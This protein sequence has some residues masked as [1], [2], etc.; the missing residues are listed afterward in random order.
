[1]FL[2]ICN[3][4]FCFARNIKIDKKIGVSPH[5]KRFGREFKGPRIPFG[6]EVMYKPSP[7]YEKKLKADG[8]EKWYNAR[9]GIFLGYKVLSGGRWRDALFVADLEDLAH[10]D[11][12]YYARSTMKKTHV[13][14]VRK[15]EVVWDPKLIP[16]YFRCILNIIKQI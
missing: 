16:L 5:Y 8:K 15:N 9:P 7:I 3:E 14:T 11:L 10:Q 6:A 12:S 2:A 1:M 13:Q 4:A